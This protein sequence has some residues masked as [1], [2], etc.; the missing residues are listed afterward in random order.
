M[1]VC[2]CVCVCVCAWIH[3][4]IVALITHTQ[5]KNKKKLERALILDWSP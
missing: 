4:C 5:K 3:K 1:C 2:V